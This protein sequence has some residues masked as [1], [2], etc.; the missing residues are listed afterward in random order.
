MQGESTNSSRADLDERSLANMC[1]TRI[2]PKLLPI[3][4]DL[5]GA[6][7]FEQGFGRAELLQFGPRL[8]HVRQRA[9]NVSPAEGNSAYLQPQFLLRE[10]HAERKQSLLGRILARAKTDT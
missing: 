9:L 5:S 1:P 3:E 6:F 10:Y 8:E 7:F 2:Q 4:L